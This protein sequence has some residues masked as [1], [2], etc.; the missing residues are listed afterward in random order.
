MSQLLNAEFE[1]EN[2]TTR[3]LN[4]DELLAYVNIIAAAGNETSA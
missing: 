2:G 1:D 4:R 3:R